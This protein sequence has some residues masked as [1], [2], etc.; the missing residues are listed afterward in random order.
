LGR[1]TQ[2]CGEKVLEIT[3][4]YMKQNLLL[5]KTKNNIL[6]ISFVLEEAFK[7]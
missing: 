3:L 1:K 4:K 2:K 6:I 7:I 5:N